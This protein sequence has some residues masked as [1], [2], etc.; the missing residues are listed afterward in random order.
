[1]K[2]VNLIVTKDELHN[3]NKSLFKANIIHQ[4]AYFATLGDLPIA[5][6]NALSCCCAT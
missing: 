1:M 3:D 4:G 5:V 2:N 6:T